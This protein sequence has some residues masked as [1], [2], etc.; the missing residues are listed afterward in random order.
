[1][2][3]VNEAKL[4]RM[5][6][7]KICGLRDVETIEAMNG[8]P[9]AEVGLVFAPSKRQVTLEQA[10]RLVAAIQRLNNGA[11]RA[12]GVFVRHPLE[13]MSQLLQH[14][15]LDVVQLHGNEE[16]NYY[17]K[18]HAAFPKV[19]LWKVISISN[20]LEESED[21]QEIIV[22]EL[23]PYVPYIECILIDAPGGG[24]G[25]PFNWKAIETYR[26]VANRFDLPLYV[27]GGLN[28]ANVGELLSL[29]ACDGIDVSSGVESEGKKDLNKIDEFVRKVIEA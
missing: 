3:Q 4:P 13:E 19:A 20:E 22:S 12:A 11:V 7:I 16:V 29:H 6:R 26:A 1:M 18:L 9:I 2:I 5:A 17:A 24:T 23:A 27:A 25:K 21:M 15:P 28:A 8:L 10:E 14:V